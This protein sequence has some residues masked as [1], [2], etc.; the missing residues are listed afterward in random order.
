MT[1]SPARR[2]ALRGRR[3][4]GV[5]RRR[6]ADAARPGRD[7]VG[8]ALVVLAG[9]A[10]LRERRLDA[11]DAAARGARGQR[12]ATFLALLARPMFTAIDGTPPVAARVAPRRNRR[13]RA[14]PMSSTL[15]RVEGRA[16]RRAQ[17]RLARRGRRLLR[18][19]QA[20][21]HRAAADHDAGSD[22]DGRARRPAAAA[23]RS[24]RCSAARS[25]PPRPARST[26]CGIATSTA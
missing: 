14:G 2:R 24:G 26:A 13:D 5:P 15:S 11:A 23:R 20:A 18:A 10:R 17:H 19:D 12:V 7:L 4:R 1:P 22:G 25:P 16:H 9:A 3:V 6:R 8:F 21:H